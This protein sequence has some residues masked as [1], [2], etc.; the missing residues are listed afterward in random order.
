MAILGDHFGSPP[1]EDFR[2]IKQRSR[3]RPDMLAKSAAA[4]SLIVIVL[5][6]SPSIHDQ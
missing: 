4:E 2:D 3:R 6:E 1:L 5:A